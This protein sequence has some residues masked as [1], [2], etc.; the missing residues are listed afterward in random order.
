MIQVAPEAVRPDYVI[1]RYTD[2]V[3]KVVRFNRSN[4]SGP[5]IYKVDKTLQ[6][7]NDHKLDNN[8]SRAHSMVLQ[9]ALCNPW[10]YFFTGTLDPL[11]FDRYDLESY[12]RTLSQW[13]RDKRKAYKSQV[14]YLL[15]PER[16]KDGAWH[17]HGLISSLPED[18]LSRFVAG[19]HPQKLVQ[20]EYY[21]WQDY[22][23][24]FGFCS[25]GRVRDPVATAVYVSKYLSKDAARRS[26]DLGQ[27]LYF[28]SRPLAT[29]ETVAN[30]YGNRSDLDRCLQAHYEF[31]SVG[32]V[33]EENWAFPLQYEEGL[34]P[35][36]GFPDAPDPR[37]LVDVTL[38]EWEQMELAIGT[39]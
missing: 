13:I 17:I 33:Y 20:G 24:K 8:F 29:A 12:Q 34:E 38:P 18:K 26:Q 16:H 7:S 31:C 2:E 10:D 19:Q 5:S 6:D 35:L 1:H 3:Y 28:H 15:V 23:S 32:M 39:V 9:Y 25:L 37:P 11:K 27:H 30:I 22:A 21:N 14:Q 36:G 4:F